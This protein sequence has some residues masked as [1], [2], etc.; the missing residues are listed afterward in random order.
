MSASPLAI[1]VYVA[2]MRPYN[3]PDQLGEGDVA[4]WAPPSS[5]LISGPTEGILI[6]ALLTFANADNIAA[7][8][9][10]FGKKIT[11][12][13]ITHGLSDHWLGLA[14]LRQH[15]PEAR[16]YAA[17]EVAARAVWEAEFNKTS[18]YWTARF[19]GELPEPPVLPEVLNTDEIL[20]DG[21]V[22]TLIHVGQGDI[23][24]STIFHVPSADAVVCG[25]VVYNN[26]HMM[27]YEADEAKR[28]AWI[29]SIDAV[30]GLNPKIVVAGHKSVGAADRPE[31]L[32][33]SQRY[34]RDFT[35]VASKGG[36]VED[37]VHGMLELH[38]ER[39][40]PHTLWISARAEVARRARTAGRTIG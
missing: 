25:D 18:K 14:R 35:T 17:P 3:F 32:A 24:G 2:P 36:T 40:Q 11:G 23:E 33:A 7:R 16:G 31:N 37:L 12:V 29:G 5:T 38:G 34:L 19:P 9:K 8:A 39:D 28:E 6:D 1:D 20:V 27:M 26:V 21:Q 15:F 30:A 10:R 4:T 13:Y 22:V